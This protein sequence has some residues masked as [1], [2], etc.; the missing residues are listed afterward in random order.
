LS[1]TEGTEN[2][3]SRGV[4]TRTLSD[5]GDFQLALAR[6]RELSDA[7][8]RERSAALAAGGTVKSQRSTAATTNHPELSPQ[9]AGVVCRGTAEESKGDIENVADPV[10][11]DDEDIEDVEADTEDRDEDDDDADADEDDDEDDDD[12]DADED[13]DED[14]C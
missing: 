6:E 4:W 7:R 13:D 5:P 2:I 3:R 9:A 11:E 1:E 14:D 12:V 10:D 8:T